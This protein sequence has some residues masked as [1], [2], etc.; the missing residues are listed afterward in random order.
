M[1]ESFDF[2]VV[3]GGSAGAVIAARLSED[4]NCRVALLEAG[5]RPPE[6]ELM[7][8]ACASLQLDPQTDW[9]FTADPGRAGLGL[10]GRRMPVPRGKMLGGSSGINYMA[11]VRG[12]PGDY[13]SWATRGATGWSYADVLPYFRKIE[14]FAPSNEIAVDAGAHGRG[15]P[16]RVGVRSPVFPACRTFVDAAGA[17]GIPRGDYNGRDR[18]GPSGV[19][20]LMQINTRGGKRCSTY[21]AYLEGDVEQRPNLTII[22]GAHVTKVLLAGEAGELAAT[23]VEYKGADGQIQ[24]VHAMCEVILS[25][26]AVGSPHLLMLSGIG[27]RRELEAADVA[28]RH[29]LP[30]VGKHLKDH[31]QCVMFFPAPGVGTAMAEI[32]VSAG[33]D[34]LRAPVGPLPADPAEDAHLTGELAALKAEAERRLAEWHATGA[35]L[36]ASSLYD[37]VAFYSTGLG[38]AHS[39]DAQIAFIP[40]GYNEDLFANRL[41][42]D[43][44]RY[45]AD[46]EALAPDRESVIVIANPI[47]PHSE[48]E[49]VLES[50][51]PAVPPAIRMNYFADP[52][53]LKVMVAVMRRALAI[54][55]AWPGPVKPGPLNVPPILASKHGYT[56]GAPPSDALLE[57]MA[58]HFSTTVYHLSCTCRVGEVVDPSLQVLGVKRLRVADASV[59][60][61]IVSGNTNAASIMIGEKA[62]EIIAREHGLSLETF[63]GGA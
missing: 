54:V 60:P 37:A 39:H 12:H 43:T 58:L 45:F 17:A 52:H 31:I 44:A 56:L 3:G 35:S 1:P 5:G 23:G 50:A 25:A 20:S 21:R 27:P 57:N 49:I 61:E 46:P 15:G 47:L 55:D 51:D 8:A 30:A 14:D 28:C 13:D 42:I 63:V 59:M 11:Y 9:M 18:G 33:P 38:D 26:G 36:I 10:H 22:T 7:P 29:E 6:H 34:A 32:G 48:G 2:I 53:D 4:A 19:A 16:V 41:N 40:C 62:A 24:A